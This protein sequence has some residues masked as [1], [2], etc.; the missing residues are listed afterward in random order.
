MAEEGKGERIEL[1]GA[2]RSGGKGQFHC[3]LQT[4]G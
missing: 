1:Y 2:D 4:E 3:L